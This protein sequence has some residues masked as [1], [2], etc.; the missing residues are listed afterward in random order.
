MKKAFLMISSVLAL[1]CVGCATTGTR[2][3]GPGETA[4]PTSDVNQDDID[5]TVS[6]AVQSLLKHDRIKL[7]SGG[8]RAVT[9]VPNTK[10]DTT[11]RGSGADALAEAITYRLQ[12]ELTNCGK[13]LV[14]DPDAAQYATVRVEPQY[15]LESVLRSRN[16]RQDN[17]RIQIEYSLNLKLIDRAT[18]TQ[19]WQ[20]SV[21]LR[22]VTDLNHAL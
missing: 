13:I 8:T 12:E 14:Y 2:I 16:V 10:I 18:G 4:A 1:I 7:L 17:G 19:Y 22:K 3:I 6:I 15:V 9:V 5:Y 20:K 11:T 21:P